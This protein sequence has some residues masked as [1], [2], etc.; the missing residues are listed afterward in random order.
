MKN[1][2]K[3]NRIGLAIY[4]NPDYY[5][6]IINAVNILAAEFDIIILCR[7]QDSPNIDYHSG[8]R[9]IRIGSIKT[10]RE[11]E[12]QPGIV[13]LLEYLVFFLRTVI[14]FRLYHCRL[15]Y[16][17]DMHSLL[18]GFLASRLGRKVPIIYHNLELTGLKEAKGM[19]YFLKCVELYLVRYVDKIIIP[20]INRARFFQKEAS[21]PKLPDVVM[22]NPLRTTQLP[23]NILKGELMARGF[24]SDTK[25]ILYQGAIGQAHSIL[26][27]VR[28]MTSWPEDTVFALS[29]IVFSE[30]MIKLQQQV[31]ALGMA[32]RVI[33]LPFLPYTQIL[34]YT[35]G[36]F[37]GIALFKSKEINQFFVAGASNKIFEYLAA[38][39]PVITNEAPH[40]RQVLDPSFAYFVRPDSV[41]DIAGAVNFAFNNPDDYRQKSRS[42]REAHLSR[43]NYQEQFKPVQ[44]YIR[45]VIYAD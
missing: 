35:V 12:A 22:N 14:D 41:E 44:E 37:L 17:Y 29:G 36:A 28:S 1:P 31:K 16:I 19:G 9:L 10:A 15:I 26:E 5:P 13:K 3:K 45:R 27:V 40:F 4:A 32:R 21:L 24:P 25:V 6:P 23:I 18:P 39:V 11:K 7:N 38:G 2:G 8:V 33:Y 34:S 20:D 42:A 43:F 30:F